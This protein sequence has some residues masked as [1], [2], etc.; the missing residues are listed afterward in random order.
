MVVIILTEGECNYLC[1]NA[2]SQ[3]M[4]SPPGKYSK[5]PDHLMTCA[6]TLKGNRE[7]KELLGG[8]CRGRKKPKFTFDPK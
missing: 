5:W 1:L 4:P 2:R 3:Q 8:R 6:S 7:T